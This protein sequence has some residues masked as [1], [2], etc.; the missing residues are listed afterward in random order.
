MCCI[1]V[2]LYYCIDRLEEI[3]AHLMREK[4]KQLTEISEVME[5]II[6]IFLFVHNLYISLENF[7]H[8]LNKLLGFIFSLSNTSSSVES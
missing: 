8:A 5:I 3:L 4:R 1:D 6:D 2:N 7:S